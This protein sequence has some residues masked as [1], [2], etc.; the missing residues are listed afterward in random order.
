MGYA[1][2]SPS[3]APRQPLHATG[4]AVQHANFFGQK[5]LR[6]W[7]RTLRLIRP[8]VLLIA[9]DHTGWDAVTRPPDSGGLGF[10]AD[11]VRRLLPPPDRRRRH[12]P[13]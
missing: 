8:T 12:P 9:E 6:E 10:D 5:L 2:T 7:S 13:G 4:Q 3:A 11:V 1:S